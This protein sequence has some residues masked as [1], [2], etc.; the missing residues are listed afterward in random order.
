MSFVRSP[1]TVTRS[2]TWSDFPLLLGVLV[3]EVELGFPLDD[4]TAK[5]PDRFSRITSVICCS[6]IIAHMYPMCTQVTN[7]LHLSVLIT[8]SPMGKISIF[9]SPLPLSCHLFSPFLKSP[10]HMLQSTLTLSPDSS[11]PQKDR[12]MLSL[13]LGSKPFVWKL[14]GF[15]FLSLYFLATSWYKDVGVLGPPL[16]SSCLL[17]ST[18]FTFSNLSQCLGRQNASMSLIL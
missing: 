18:S 11:G 17:F 14:F 13:D 5:L 15:H 12:H 6:L 7:S 16:A 3:V 8:S 10:L 2:F 9:P 4:E 1:I